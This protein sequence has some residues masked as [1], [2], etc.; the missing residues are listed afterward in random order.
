MK[1]PNHGKHEPAAAAAATT[2]EAPTTQSTNMTDP[3]WSNNPPGPPADPPTEAEPGPPPGWSNVGASG[4][5]E[6]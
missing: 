6:A 2:G 4:T 1:T 5:R 3:G